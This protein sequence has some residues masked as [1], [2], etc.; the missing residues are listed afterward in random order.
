MAPLHD[1]M[2]NRMIM[3]Y[4]YKVGRCWSP[5]TKCMQTGKNLFLRKAYYVTQTADFEAVGYRILCE[6]A[7]MFEALQGAFDEHEI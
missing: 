1:W 3:R 4:S 2:L 7:F 5:F 6:E